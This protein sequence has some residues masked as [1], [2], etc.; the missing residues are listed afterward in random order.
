MMTKLA[1]FVSLIMTTF[2][3]IHVA[4]TQIDH[5]KEDKTLQ[6]AHKVFVDD[7]EKRLEDLY[8]VN[9]EMGLE[10]EHADCNQFI[11][12]YLNQNFKLTVNGKEVQ[13]NWVGKELE[14]PA[15]WIYIEYPNVK[16]PKSIKVENRILFETFNDQKNLVHFNYNGI[17]RSLILKK[18][19][20]VGEVTFD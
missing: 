15:V 4:V 18:E 11:T 16:K 14:G 19:E 10:K 9:L 1:L 2:H 7:F 17:K 13:G 12:K 6:V 20:E 3:P 5:D 8:Q